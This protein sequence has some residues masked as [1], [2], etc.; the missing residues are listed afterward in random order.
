MRGVITCSLLLFFFLHRRRVVSS[1]RELF[2]GR[3]RWRRRRLRDPHFVS[4]RGH[5]PL[6]CHSSYRYQ[7]DT[8]SSRNHSLRARQDFLFT[9]LGYILYYNILV[10]LPLF[11]VFHFFK[12]QNILTVNCYARRAP[13]MPHIKLQLQTHCGICRRRKMLHVVRAI[14]DA[15]IT[16]CVVR[17]S[18]FGAYL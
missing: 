18:S 9:H 2:Q 4:A 14:W 12:L 1:P 15:Q 3:T 6:H 16:G 10:S 8:L 17:R 7:T 11:V 13:F 5:A